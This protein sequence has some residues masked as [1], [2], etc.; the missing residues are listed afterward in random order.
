VE[1]RQLNTL[2]V[3]AEAGS[4]TEAAGQLKISQS[5][6]S[7][8]ILLLEK[9]LGEA[10]F[11]RVG[12]SIRITPAGTTV[13]ALSRRVSADIDQVA[14]ALRD[15]RA[16]LT[17]TIRLVGGMTVCLHVYPTLIKEFQSV[18]PGVDVKVTPGAMQRILRKL[19]N[20]SAD[21]GLLT[22]PIDDPKLS[23][24]P[25]MREELVLV[26]SPVHALTRRAEVRPRD[27]A[28][29]DFVLFESGSNTRLAI[30]QFFVSQHLSPKIVTET[31]NV[32]IIKAPRRDRHRR[33]DHSVLGG[34]AG[35]ALRPASRVADCRTSTLPRNRLGACQV[36]GLA[37]CG[38][39]NEE[40][41]AA[42]ARQTAAPAGCDEP[43][44]RRRAGRDTQVSVRGVRYRSISEFELD[45]AARMAALLRTTSSSGTE[46]CSR[47]HDASVSSETS[48]PAR[49]RPVLP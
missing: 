46:K 44:A 23:C 41:V 49:I 27:L 47:P 11:L 48:H 29:L 31:D 34:V 37:A 35:G 40:R 18:H 13:L 43:D 38:R 30:E 20:G 12:R 6:V 28:G 9:E 24:E 5:S 4:F 26:T 33:D 7:R 25:V 2:R 19:R 16:H 8:Q 1:L 15:K 14:A 32:E 45:E 22:L 42:R 10:L 21:L 17:G 39:G 3:V 36:Q